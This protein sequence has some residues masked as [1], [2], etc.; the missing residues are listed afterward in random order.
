MSFPRTRLQRLRR[1]GGIRA[2]VREVELTPRMLVYPLFVDAA[3]RAPQAVAALPGQNRQTL[4]TVTSTV[5]EAKENGVHTF[6]LFGLPRGKDPRAR[7]ASASDGVV[8][9]TLNILRQAFGDTITLVTDVCL[10]G[11]TDHGH[12]GILGDQGI[13]NDGTLDILKEVA[14]SHV[15]HGADIV[16]PSGMMDGQVRAIRGALDDAG[17]PSAAIL[18]YAAKHASGFYGPFR[19]AA[20]SA[21]RTGDRRGYQLDYT[22]PSQALRE[23][24][25]DIQEGAD[26]VMVKPALA[27]LDLVYR[28]KRRFGVPT[29]AYNVSGEY[30][31]VKAAA[32]RGWLDERAAVL[33][34]LTAIRRAG[35]DFI[36]TYHAKEAAPWLAQR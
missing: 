8:Q 3:A 14:V 36:V 34:I 15:I 27:Y 2:L 25:L 30:A 35:A 6:L 31:M 23:V 20:N 24:A 19:E 33:E 16:A 12:C 5:A 1:T 22:T 17:Y 9:Q 32:A 29:A 4:D 10:C 13:D 7:E 11:Y 28:V 21:P 26:M 18:S